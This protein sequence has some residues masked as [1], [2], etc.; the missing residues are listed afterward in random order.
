MVV[1]V[2]ESG[3]RQPVN[4]HHSLAA[5]STCSHLPCTLTSHVPCQRPWVAEAP[6]A[7][8][9]F[10]ASCGFDVS[11]L[12]RGRR[13]PPS[14][15]SSPARTLID[16]PGRGE[17]RERPRRDRAP[18]TNTVCEAFRKH[19]GL[20][21]TTARRAGSLLCCSGWP[22]GGGSCSLSGVLCARATG[23][24]GHGSRRS[25]QHNQN[26]GQH[27]ARPGPDQR[28]FQPD[29]LVPRRR[30]QASVRCCPAPRSERPCGCPKHAYNSGQPGSKQ[31]GQGDD[32]CRR[33]WGRRRWWQAAGD[34][35][36]GTERP[37][38]CPGGWRAG[39][40]C[41]EHVVLGR[42]ERANRPG[43]NGKCGR[44]QCPDRG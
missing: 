28:P 35:C 34:Q 3:S 8:P 31:A 25:G 42:R 5:C 11:R 7:E 30:G 36:P 2:L 22:T 40:R 13:S 43:R 21:P 27:S 44:G 41:S 32:P 9:A 29:S 15:P 39:Q 26:H 12:S 18:P 1:R 37:D 33:C 14:S 38:G 24:W 23:L 17:G 6:P 16:G 19:H 20:S 4:H 10:I